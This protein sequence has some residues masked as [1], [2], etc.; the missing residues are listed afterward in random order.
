MTDQQR[1]GMTELVTRFRNHPV[2]ADQASRMQH[3][4]HGCLELAKTIDELC[5]HS[6]ERSDALTNL[7]YVMYQALASIE[8]RETGRVASGAKDD[9]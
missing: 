2:N 7:D 8:R 9:R 3:I 6:R 4:R 5:P 1:I